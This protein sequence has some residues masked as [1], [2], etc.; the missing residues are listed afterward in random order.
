M[1]FTNLISEWEPTALESSPQTGAEGWQQFLC[2]Q[3]IPPRSPFTLFLLNVVCSCVLLQCFVVCVSPCV[4]ITQETRDIQLTDTCPPLPS[5][6]LP[7]SQVSPVQTSSSGPL[8]AP[9][10][11]SPSYWLLQPGATSKC[12]CGL[13]VWWVF[14]SPE[15]SRLVVK[16]QPGVTWGKLRSDSWHFYK[17]L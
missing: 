13:H 3:F 12:L 9:F 2:S 16:P 7:L 4:H 1:K 8:S 17:C 15:V 11:S 10:S 5:S 14:F 6:S